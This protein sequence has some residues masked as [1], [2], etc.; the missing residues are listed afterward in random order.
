MK[1][2]RNCW[3][4]VGWAD[5]VGTA[6]LSREILG[7]TIFFYRLEDGTPAAIL[8]RCPH[9]FA[10]FSKGER[11]GDVLVCGYHGLGFD[12]NGHCVRNP[13]SA[14]IPAG[15]DVPVWPVVERHGILW[16]WAGDA[17][18]ID[19][20]L[21]PDFSFVPDTPA[22]RS[23]RGYTLMKAHFEYG[24][25]NLMDLSHIEFVHRGT[26][27]GQGIIFQGEH[28]IRQEGETLHSDW[29]MPN[30]TPPMVAQ[31]LVAAG[32][33]VDHWLRM[34]WNAP[35][36]MRLDV[37]ACPHGAPESAGFDIPQAHILT[38]ANEHE[39]HYFWSASRN[40][41]IDSAEADAYMLGLF[42][43]AFDVE[44]KPMIEAAYANVRGKDF[45][46]EKPVS[47][48]IDQGGT[49]ARRLLESL[50]AKEGAHG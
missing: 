1:H 6:G 8:D 41:D 9:R 10:P 3:Y 22:L 30:I 34:R 26:F 15:T 23:V 20:N 14:R 13:F 2:L 50:I 37:G 29:W 45:W 28:S 33:T 48:G 24:T 18:R 43:E 32:E 16:L 19:Q 21:I 11:D 27:A 4:M 42:R 5:D 31:G 7:K 36:S 49:R 47:L 40:H 12:R 44:D 39:T 17:D 35:A 38:P 46:G 25:D